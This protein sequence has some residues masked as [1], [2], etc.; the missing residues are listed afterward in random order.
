MFAK[1]T[2]G[3]LYCFTYNA[4]SE[5]DSNTVLHYVNLEF[6]GYVVNIAIATR[7]EVADRVFYFFVDFITNS[8]NQTEIA[9]IRML[10]DSILVKLKGKYLDFIITEKENADSCKI[11]QIV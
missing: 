6:K 2:D 11:E 4:T 5:L 7:K 1:F 10:Q 3:G 9:F 8:S